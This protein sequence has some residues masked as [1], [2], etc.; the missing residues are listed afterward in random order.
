MQEYIP[1]EGRPWNMQRVMHVYRRL[2]FSLHYSELESKLSQ[3]P[4]SLID[5]LLDEASEAEK[6]PSPEWA[7]WTNL[8]FKDFEENQEKFYEW[9][10]QWLVRMH[11]SPLRQK[12]TLFWH[13]HFVT[14]YQTYNCAPAAY[15]Y[16]DLLQTYSMSNFKE[17]VKAIGKDATMLIFLNGTQST[18][19]NPNENYARELYEL[20][21][22]GRD[23]GYTQQD[24]EETARAL[25]GWVVYPCPTVTFID[26][27]WDSGEKT[28]F[29]QTGPWGYNDV[30]DILFEQRSK[31]I[32]RFVVSKL[33]KEFVYQ[34]ISE[35]IIQELADYFIEV[36]FEILPILRKLFKS[37]HFFDEAIIGN[38]IKSPVEL[39]LNFIR[40]VGFPIDYDDEV[41]ST[42]GAVSS[43]LGQTLFQPPN[44]AG[45]PGHR[46]WISSAHL[47][48]R[49]EMITYYLGGILDADMESMRKL[50]QSLS[51]KH[52]DPEV[53]TQ[54]I[55]DYFLP[56]GLLDVVDYE[57]AIA[58]FK[59]D[60]PSNYFENG[61]WSLAW[62]EAPYQ[63]ALLLIH[64][65][66]LP[67]FQMV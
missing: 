63:V 52:N 66:R 16:L 51:S 50:A 38:K 49:W 40:E 18:R 61:S 36:E 3:N 20:F 55:V 53:T 46:S 15:K 7:D 65:I 58:T 34:D 9:A 28:I 29:G 39:Q 24:I 37:E 6:I 30:I 64:L 56:M 59:G 23:T 45:W 54:A 25:T 57:K 17:F 4:S 35:S 60:I 44:V 8:D 11:Q 48:T 13:N 19:I 14:Q 22:L 10:P 5:R 43:F 41:P 27:L 21:T 67:E 42:I 31:E 33:Y 32:A 12:M 62:D 1:Y 47:R 2:G 26:S